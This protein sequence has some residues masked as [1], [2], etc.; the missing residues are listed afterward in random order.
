VCG[1]EAFKNSKAKAGRLCALFI[2]I[3]F[4]RPWDH[5]LR[6]LGSPYRCPKAQCRDLGV[7]VIIKA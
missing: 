7:V 5:E 6:A 2:H 3:S 4:V 1:V